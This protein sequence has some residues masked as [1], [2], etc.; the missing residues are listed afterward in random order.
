MQLSSYAIE[1]MGY[2]KFPDEEQISVKF[3]VQRV[4]SLQGLNF[5]KE[6]EFLISTA[7]EFGRQC[8][9]VIAESVNEVANEISGEDYAENED[10]WVV[11]KKARPPYLLVCF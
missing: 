9:V 7:F 11:E 6:S 4:Y 2:V 5:D 8:K 3:A 10:E 1:K